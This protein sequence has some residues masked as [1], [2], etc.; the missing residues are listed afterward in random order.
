MQSFVGTA[1]TSS[2]AGRTLIKYKGKKRDGSAI[3][4][5][6]P[7]DSTCRLKNFFS[8]AFP[9]PPPHTH[10][11]RLPFIAKKDKRSIKKVNVFTS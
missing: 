8:W 9:S 3:S 10:T 6:H 5:A 2:F 11:H 1:F 7:N 4:S